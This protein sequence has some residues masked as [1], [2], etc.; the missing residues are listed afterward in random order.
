MP[1]VSIASDG[2]VA[3]VALFSKVPVEQHPL[4]CARLELADID[5]VAASVVHALV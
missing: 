5:S 1:G 2:P 4:D 3:S